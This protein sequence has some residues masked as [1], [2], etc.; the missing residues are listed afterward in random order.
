VAFTRETGKDKIGNPKACAMLEVPWSLVSRGSIEWK[1]GVLEQLWAVSFNLPWTPGS[2]DLSWRC[3]GRLLTVQESKLVAKKPLPVTFLE[4]AGTIKLLVMAKGSW[5][6]GAILDTDVGVYGIRLTMG[7]LLVEKC[8]QTFLNYVQ[9]PL[10]FWEAG[11]K[12]L[13]LQKDF[14]SA[15]CETLTAGPFDKAKRVMML[16]RCV[17]VCMCV[18]LL[19]AR[20]MPT[21]KQLCTD[22]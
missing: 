6:P 17:C 11:A 10:P 7:N 19:F 3:V 2:P 1:D 12:K 9:K 21:N 16:S 13:P 5:L 20:I 18:C 14:K 22:S 15:I 8:C 4:K